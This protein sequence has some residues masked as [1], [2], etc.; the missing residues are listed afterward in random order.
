MGIELRQLFFLLETRQPRKVAIISLNLPLAHLLLW[1]L[2][3][4]YLINKNLLDC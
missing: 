4:H 2:L 3:D 1:F